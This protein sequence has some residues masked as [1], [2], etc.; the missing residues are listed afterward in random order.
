VDDDGPAS[1][2]EREWTPKQRGRAAPPD[3]PPAREAAKRPDPSRRR[4]RGVIVAGAVTLVVAAV[5][6]VCSLGPVRTV[7][8]QSFTQISSPT[9]Q[10]FFNG[11]PWVSGELLNVPL[12]VDWHSSSGPSTYNVRIWMVDGGGKTDFSST[13]ALPVRDG[14][15][16]ENFSLLIPTGGQVVWAQVE[17]T[18]LSLHYRF[19]GS[20]LAS[21]SSTR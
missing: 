21:P 12:G 18:S 13:V 4:R 14:T 11:D 5:Y 8:R 19:A 9:L 16:A 20:A 15:G 10:F 2:D 17:G 3:K 6:G 7:L 1:D